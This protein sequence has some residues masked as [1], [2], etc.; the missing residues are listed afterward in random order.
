MTDWRTVGSHPEQLA[1][2]SLVQGL[3]GLEAGARFLDGRTPSGMG[4][5]IA[6]DRGG[7]LVELAHAGRML[8]WI[9]PGH[10]PAAS[11]PDPDGEDGLGLLRSF[12]G[13]LV[14]CGYDYFGPPRTGPARHFRYPLRERV[15]YPVHG[16]AAFLPAA[17]EGRRIE[18]DAIRID[19]RLRQAS[20]F[21]SC[22]DVRRRWEFLLDRA[23]VRLTDEVENVG[24]SPS[25]FMTLYHINFGHPLITEG[26][27][28]IGL[29][30]HPDMPSPLPPMSD[31]T[32]ERGRFIP[33]AEVADTVTIA[34][35]GGTRVT[36]DFDRAAFSHVGQWWNRY[37]GMNCV[38]VEP[39]TAGMPPL[40]R[41]EWEPADWIGPGETR[42]LSVGMK[43]VG[44]RG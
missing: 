7:D 11:A 28:I 24:L 2:V 30:P 19:L 34:A 26:T 1:R 25:P 13:L 8:G 9:G 23:E 36:L 12:S 44:G 42:T 39:A 14:T 29:P 37:P 10:H 20:L 33:R 41:H 35:P 32:T 15:H 16:R 18:G 21:G 4:F 38:A 40:A 27:E 17:I 22:L 3:D 43:I 5:R 31:D 6:L